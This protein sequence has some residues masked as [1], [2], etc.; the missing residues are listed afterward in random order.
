MYPHFGSIYIPSTLDWAEKGFSIKQRTIISRGDMANFTTTGHGPLEIKLRV[1]GW[2]R[3]GFYISVDEEAQSTKDVQSS[4]Y[5]S[6]RRIW[7]TGNVVQVHMP[8]SIQNERALDRPDTQPI[9]WEPVLLQSIGKPVDRSY[10]QLSLYRSLKRDGDYQQAAISQIGI[11]STGDPLFTT[12][13]P[14]SNILKMRP[15]YMSDT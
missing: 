3:K 9:M 13:S 1:P 10:W 4:T 2:G 7:K 12:V 5:W 8:L 11:T 6:L 14:T 15:Y